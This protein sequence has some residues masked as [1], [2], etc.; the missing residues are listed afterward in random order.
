MNYRGVS[1]IFH[2]YY[3]KPLHKRSVLGHEHQAL[4]KGTG[5]S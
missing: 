3:V 4:Y 5:V 1:D 2:A